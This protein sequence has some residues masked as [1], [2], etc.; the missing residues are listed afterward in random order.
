MTLSNVASG[1]RACRTVDD[2]ILDFPASSWSLPVKIFSAAALP[3]NYRQTLLID[4]HGN[5]S[6][7][8]LVMTR[9]EASILFFLKANTSERY[10]SPVPD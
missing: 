8:Y 10:L 2:A 7:G 3:L 6:D 9:A 1:T 5:S 4:N